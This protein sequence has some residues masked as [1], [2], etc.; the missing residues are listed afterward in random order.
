VTNMPDQDAYRPDD[1]IKTMSGLH[2]EITNTDAE[3]R[4]ILCDALTYS[5]RYEPRYV[6]DVATLTGAI[7]MALGH[8]RSGLFS[9]NEDLATALTS[10][11]IESAD[12]TWRFPLDPVYHE[13]LKSTIAD[14]VNSGETLGGRSITA[15]CFLSRFAE[16][17]QWAHL[18]IAGIA[19]PEKKSEYIT[20]RPVPLLVEFLMQQCAALQ[21]G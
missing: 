9:N 11:S 18:D 7:I 4:M 21:K 12:P 17:L 13:P 20:G 1:V 2:I 8:Y 10:A 3:G 15:A 6:V 19:M 16:D 5:K 14:M